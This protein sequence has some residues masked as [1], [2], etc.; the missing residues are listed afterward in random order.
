MAVFPPSWSKEQMQSQMKIQ[1]TLRV[2]F[3][4]VY[5]K[6]YMDKQKAKKKKAQIYWRKRTVVYGLF[7]WMLRL[8]IKLQ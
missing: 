4:Q 2:K 3:E 6:T 5:S 7:C 8:I 1:Q